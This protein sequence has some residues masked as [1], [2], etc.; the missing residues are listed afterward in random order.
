MSEKVAKIGLLE[1]SLLMNLKGGMRAGEA[2][3]E[4]CSITMQGLIHS[5][6][7]GD[8]EGIEVFSTAAEAWL[9]ECDRVIEALNKIA[10][11]PET[12]GRVVQFVN[13]GKYKSADDLPVTIE[14]I[15]FPTQEQEHGQE[16]D[17][18]T[19]VPVHSIKADNEADFD[20]GSPRSE[21]P[22]G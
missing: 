17:S 16:S 4:A 7:N 2:L 5:Y 19:T 9:V 12:G 3:T 8:T 10:T 1:L 15:Q 22:P 20:S 14:E 21:H 11:D 13:D 6:T 18:Q